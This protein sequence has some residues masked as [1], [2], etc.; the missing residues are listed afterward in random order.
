MAKSITNGVQEHKNA[1]TPRSSPYAASDPVKSLTFPR[2]RQRP[3]DEPNYWKEKKNLTPG[4]SPGS[5]PASSR[6]NSEAITVTSDSQRQAARTGVPVDGERVL[7][8]ARK[9]S[10][11][12][13]DP[14][15]LA[16]PAHAA[17]NGEPVPRK[18]KRSS[19]EHLS[20]PVRSKGP[21]LSSLPSSEPSKT[22]RRSYQDDSKELV[23]V[24]DSDLNEATAG[25]DT[26]FSNLQP[27]SKG[28]DRTPTKSPE[29]FETRGSLYDRFMA[30]PIWPDPRA[31]RRPVPEIPS[32]DLDEDH[33]PSRLEPST[34]TP[35]ENGTFKIPERPASVKPQENPTPTGRGTPS[36]EVTRSRRADK[37]S[38]QATGTLIVEDNLPEF[39]LTLPTA[40]A[41]LKQHLNELREDQDQFVR[42]WLGRARRC[43]DQTSSALAPSFTD[44]A[45][46]PIRTNEDLI[47]SISP[48][49]SLKPLSTRISGKGNEKG[50]VSLTQD[51]M[52]DK[53]TT[54]KA[55]RSYLSVQVSCPKHAKLSL[56]EYTSYVGL[57]QNVLAENDQTLL[58]WP[59]MGENADE[60]ALHEEL[61]DRFNVSVEERHSHLER[62]AQLRKFE[63]Y[64]QDYL[65]ELGCSMNDILRFYLEPLLPRSIQLTDNVREAISCRDKCCPEDFDR[66]SEKWIM[67]L[68]RLLPS[69]D[70]ALAAAALAC[71]SFTNLCKLSLWHVALQIVS[72]DSKAQ[73]IN[74]ISALENLPTS[75]DEFRYRD[76]ACRVCHLHNCNYH[77]EYRES[78][79]SS[80]D[81]GIMDSGGYSASG[82][83]SLD[84]ED[85]TR[86]NF[87]RLVKVQPRHDNL[88]EADDSAARLMA[89]RRGYQYWIQKSNTHLI[90]DREPFYPCSHEGSCEE[91]QCRC[92][93]NKIT[94]EKSCACSPNC[95]RRFRGC[96]CIQKGKVCFQ[97]PHCDCYRL[98]RECDPDL[99][100]T[101]GAVE[102]LDPVNR[103][104]KD[105]AR[106]K[107]ANVHIQ[108]NLPK[109]TLLG[110]SEVQGFGLYMGEPVKAHEYIGEY[111]GE[112][113]TKGEA[114]R[115]GAIY[116]HLATNYLFSL[117]KGQEVDSTKA[118]N[119]MRFINNSEQE[120]TMN[121]Y[122]QTM[123]CNS[124]TR[125]GMYARRDIAVGE[126]LFF[127]YGYPKTI[128]KHF[129]EKGEKPKKAHG[130]SRGKWRA[131][132][133][134]VSDLDDAPTGAGAS[135]SSR[136]ASAATTAAASG[137]GSSKAR[138][139]L[140]KDGKLVKKSNAGGARPGA[141]RKP[142]NRPP[143]SVNVG[144]IPPNPSTSSAAQIREKEK[145]KGTG[146]GKGKGKLMTIERSPPPSRPL[147]LAPVP[148]QLR[149]KYPGSPR[150]EWMV[151]EDDEDDESFPDREVFEHDEAMDGDEDGDESEEE[152]QVEAGAEGEM[153]EAT[154]APVSIED[155]DGDPEWR[156]EEEARP[157]RQTRR[158]ARRITR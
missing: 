111:K 74:D 131:S 71:H 93:R 107:C 41:L 121:C 122:A 31:L 25:I 4:T 137:G 15:R 143:A 73:N 43:Y 75:M 104:N 105:V 14:F 29:T 39:D 114:D 11:Q 64:I 145:E 92:F 26:S 158:S 65:A 125:I 54:H 61:E 106:G 154:P 34:V 91:E 33:E 48:F 129:W 5:P 20:K 53:S 7:M 45:K 60:S 85:G 97:N 134:I 90:H 148:Q 67:M 66:S 56:P 95:E 119:K 99:C 116:A 46:G 120:E 117:N 6:T 84:G 63:P 52:Y 16:K 141:G 157:R 50:H 3:R 139:R 79:Y 82:G 70:R 81:A 58:Y 38:Q 55:N 49:S 146:K 140:D 1:T 124:V 78:P 13:L 128:T 28:L 149:K 8:A 108:R 42:S 103:Y 24:P 51:V 80:S 101:C 27:R 88:L 76:L 10:Q 37:Q 83:A 151:I 21:R 150:Q 156:E 44:L 89:P 18:R 22:S 100:G 2:Q 136:V 47:H 72:K 153:E 17:L 69:S 135:S 9:S 102:V 142:K 36:S 40:E 144:I 123:L 86:I 98:N 77:G 155:S 115:R 132:T 110:H 130:T 112:V 32:S 138:W 12:N 59:Y 127:N 87:K 94:C 126:E 19:G 23:K 68:S 133:T 30:A 96:Q 152:A 113:I 62:S 57:R 109:K 35:L 147:I 118:G